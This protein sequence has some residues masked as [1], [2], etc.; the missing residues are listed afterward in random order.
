MDT[1]LGIRNFPDDNTGVGPSS[2]KRNVGG[3]LEK[4]ILSSFS[5]LSSKLP[6]NA[7]DELITRLGGTSK[8][9]EVSDTS[10]LLYI[11]KHF[12]FFV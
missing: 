4:E 2:K 1:V 5:I 9:C 12:V 6:R 8:V 10:Y 3:P 7:L 11:F